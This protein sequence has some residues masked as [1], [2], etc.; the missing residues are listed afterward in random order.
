MREDEFFQTF[1]EYFL[2][3][4]NVLN[5][6]TFR[7]NAKAFGIENIDKSYLLTGTD[8]ETSLFEF[9]LC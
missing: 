4:G 9:V 6:N 3:V 1:L 8:K 2:A 7:G 5:A